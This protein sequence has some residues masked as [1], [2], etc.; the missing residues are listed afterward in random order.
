MLK[1]YEIHLLISF[2]L[3]CVDTWQK[4]IPY[5]LCKYL[6]FSD[7]ISLNGQSRIRRLCICLYISYTL[8]SYCYTGCVSEVIRDFVCKTIHFS[9]VQCE[10]GSIPV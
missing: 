2:R 10:D 1:K 8:Y 6:L 7:Y 4:C 5:V 3:K 9:V